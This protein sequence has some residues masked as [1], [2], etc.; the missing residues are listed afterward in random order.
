[1]AEDNCNWYKC[2][3]F[4]HCPNCHLDQAKRV[5]RFFTCCP[6]QRCRRNFY[7]KMRHLGMLDQTGSTANPSQKKEAFLFRFNKTK[8]C[9][10]NGPVWGQLAVF[11]RFVPKMLRIGD[12]F[13]VAYLGDDGKLHGIYRL[14]N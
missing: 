12:I 1:M 10:R 14:D 7:N 2:S 11:L 4:V 8:Y 6:H 13:E 9:P 3:P 5:E